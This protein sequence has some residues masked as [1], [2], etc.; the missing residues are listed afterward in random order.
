MRDESI[1]T[2]GLFV[3]FMFEFFFSIPFMIDSLVTA[4]KEYILFSIVIFHL[5]WLIFGRV[6]MLKRRQADIH[7]LGFIAFI[8]SFIPLVGFLPHIIVAWRTGKVLLET[9]NRKKE[10]EV[11][12][13]DEEYI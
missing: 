9:F 11:E 7:I 5:V 1:Y 13:D 12:K 8:I 10:D 4:D 2:G 6:W 3:L